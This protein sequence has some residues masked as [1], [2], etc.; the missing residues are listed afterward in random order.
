VTGWRWAGGVVLLVAAIAACQEQLTQPAD[1]P[2]LCPGG[3]SEVFDTVVSAV[4]DRDSSFPALKD[5]A[6]GYIGRGN[7]T[8]LLVSN[9]FAPSEDR[10]VY[11]FAARA[12]AVVLRDTLRT[13][14]VD[15]VLLSMT[16]TARDTLVNGLK[17]YLYRLPQPETVDSTRTFADIDPLL[18]GVNLI[19]SIAVPDSV[20]AGAITT[21]LRGADVAKLG[22]APGGDS[23][24]AVG[25][26]IAAESPTGIRVGAL[27]SNTAANYTSYLTLDV[28]DT[29]VARKQ[30]MNRTTAFNTF[31]T[32]N[33]L[34]PD[35]T[36]L[37]VGGEPSSRALLRFGLSKEFL[38][39]ST[40]VRATL[41]LT[42][43]RPIL[44]LPTDPSAL[45]TIA[46]VGDLGAKSPLTADVTFILQDTLP[47]VQSDTVRLEVT[48]IVQLWQSSRERPQSMFL[49]LL[50]EGA[51]FARAVFHS[52]RSH[53]PEGTLVAPRL[54]ITYQR[55]FPFENP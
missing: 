54:R 22:L 17:I 50:P 28:P 45:Q 15:S 16:L 23:V 9:G 43:V 11:R 41:E 12:G 4:Q 1:C 34:V 30:S 44:G 32:Q 10:A 2:A 20:N 48:R 51:T 25:L 39:S 35:D 46:V 14:T 13:Y 53:V 52:T 24:L 36:L 31:V 33:P 49:R 55:F 42:P 18:T 21:M 5:S 27:A 29:G 19:D 47:A 3:T 26:R 38:D 37:T 6:S 40:I 7:G 8:A